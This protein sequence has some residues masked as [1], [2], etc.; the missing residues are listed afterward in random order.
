MGKLQFGISSMQLGP[1]VQERPD[2]AICLPE[3]EKAAVINRFYRAGGHPLP[4]SPTECRFLW[5]EQALYVLGRHT[6]PGGGQAVTQGQSGDRG[7]QRLLRP[8]GFQ[9]IYSP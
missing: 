5:D 1:C 9:R 4:A 6:N 3:W 7:E 2:S 8:S